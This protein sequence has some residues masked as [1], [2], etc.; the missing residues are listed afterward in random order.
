MAVLQNIRNR[1]GLLIGIIALALLAFLLGDMLQNGSFGRPDRTLA[2]INGDDISVD[3]YQARLNELTEVYKMN[4]G[5]VALDNEATQRVQDETWNALVRDKIMEAEYAETGFA[6]TGD[7][8]FDMVQGDNVH[9]LIQQ[10]FSNPQTGQVDKSQILNFLKSFEMEGGQ[11]REAYWMFIENELTRSR[12][13]EKYNIALSKGLL[14]NTEEAKF[15]IATM[16]NAKSV[17]FFSV[18]YSTISDSTIDVSA[19]EI[20]AYF[21]AH[22]ASYTQEEARN[23]E[24]VSFPIVASYEDDQYVEDWSEKIAAEFKTIPLNETSRY[25]RQNSDE[26]WNEKFLGKTQVAEPLTDFAF[27]NELGDIYGPYKEGD[28]YKVAK[29]VAR[30]MRPDSVQASHILIQEATPE[31]TEELADSLFN[32]L[33]K[34]K[35]KMADLAKTYSKDQG[36]AMNGGDLGWFAD[37]LMVKPFNDASFDGKVGEVQKVTSQYGIHLLIVNKKSKAVEKVKIATVLR[38]VEASNTTYRNIYTEASKLRSESTDLNSFKASAKEA[39]KRIRY[40]NNIMRSSRT[41]MGLKDSKELVRW[42]Y[43]AEAGEIS[44]VIE[45][46]GQ[47]IVASLSGVKEKGYRSIDE[48]SAMIKSTLIKEKK[49]EQIINKINKAQESSKTITSLAAKMNSTINSA[50]NIS[51]SSYSVPQ[52]G[53]EPKLVGAISAA[54]DGIVSAPIEGN[55]GV[56][57]FKVNETTTSDN[58]PGIEDEKQNLAQT[59]SYMVNYQAYN[60]LQEAAEIKDMRLLYY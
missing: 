37:G 48:V 3:E 36:S 24:Y 28:T 54:K 13:N 29:L 55:R 57:V 10:I 31:R 45:V 15:N 39:Q 16:K 8:I 30:E 4:T 49:A 5:Q 53:V 14:A 59:K 33:S 38:A 20:K 26:T 58:T 6:V 18:P 56:Y 23:I 19:S 34:N 12:K 7:E 27:S 22:K 44:D 60:S 9:P 25:V 50:N 11:E 42:A 47:F 41:V 35:R 43:K 32:V 52:A 21:N 51:F 17:D 1:A 46:D 2:E 40:G